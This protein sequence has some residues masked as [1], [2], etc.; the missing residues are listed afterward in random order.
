MFI[1]PFIHRGEVSEDLNLVDTVW[2]NIV[3]LHD[4]EEVAI[5]RT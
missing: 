2:L 1:D 5:K 4:G 3:I